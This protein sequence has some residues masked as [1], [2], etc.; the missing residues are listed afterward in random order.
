M[1]NFNPALNIRAKARLSRLLKAQSKIQSF[2]HRKGTRK[3]TANVNMG[4]TW[5]EHKV[6]HEG[7]NSV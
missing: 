4:N 5:R 7:I 3:R 1:F 6:Q 2:L